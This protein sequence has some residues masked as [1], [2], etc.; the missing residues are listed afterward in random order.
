L[1]IPGTTFGIPN[2]WWKAWGWSFGG[3]N[4]PEKGAQRTGP[5]GGA[6]SEVAVT[7]ER[8]L[9][10]STAWSCVR[11]I[12]ETV[13]AFP[14]SFSRETDGG[15]RPLEP[16]HYMVQLLKHRPN[17]LMP[18]HAYREAQVMGVVLWGNHYSHI[19]REGD[20]VQGLSPLR[21]DRM[22]PM[23]TALGLQYH[24]KTDAGVKVYAPESILHVRGFGADGLVGLS[25]LAYARQ[26]LGLA[27]ATDRYAAKTFARGGR[28]TGTLTFDKFLSKEQR[29][30]A[31]QLYDEL[32]TGDR[33][34]LP[35]ILEGGSKY[36]AIDMPPDDMQMLQTRAF[37]VADICRFYRV[38]SHMV[39]DSEK[40]TT[41]GT[42]IEE[43]NL[44]FLAYT[45]RPY[46]TRLESAYRDSLLSSAERDTVIV[47]HNVEGLLRASSEKRAAFYS[48]M[49]QNGLYSRNEV[50]RKENMSE[51]E[52]G[53]E[54]T[55]QVNL[56]PL[57][58][59][60]SFTDA[61]TQKPVA[62]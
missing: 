44:G 35:L 28:P 25:P 59:L 38:P 53:D 60:R 50:R 3:I 49:V 27:I 13:G 7:D 58:Q 8:A 22:T 55:V 37:N 56:T 39:N 11:L 34:G 20:R 40:S 9:Q 4:N 33:A 52:G 6:E 45:I 2:S 30:Q 31:Q 12:V 29:L 41:Y 46:L 42:G 61:K 17:G 32:Q 51:V 23:R 24:Y 18:A 26:T 54:L 21:S 48:Q 47:E 19:V 16:D 5:G 57:D 62:G 1:S 36:E 14:L 43:I 10:V 15:R